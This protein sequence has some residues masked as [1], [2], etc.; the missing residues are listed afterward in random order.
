LGRYLQSDPIGLDGGV[1]TYA[2]V[3]GNP[4]S[5]IDPTGLELCSIDLPGLGSDHL[6]TNFAPAVQRWIA[7]N[8]ASGINVSFSSAF[9]S[10]EHQG[11][12]NPSNATT[13]APP[14]NSLHEAGYAVDINWSRL[15]AQQRDTV[16]ANASASGLSWG[17]NFRAPDPVHFF[18]DPGNRAALIQDAQARYA[19]GRADDCSCGN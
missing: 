5:F 6:D 7:A 10:T 17:G 1:N 18:S 15:N 16:V 11:D 13:P 9:R 12:L 8:S 3:D 14:G 19:D 4:T 2:Y